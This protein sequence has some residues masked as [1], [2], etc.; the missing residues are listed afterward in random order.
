MEKVEV[1]WFRNNLRCKDNPLLL[2]KEYKV[3]PVFIF[4]EEK[5]NLRANF[6]FK[7]ILNLKENL[8]NMAL[9]L[10]LFYGKPESVFDYIKEKFEIVKIYTSYDKNFPEGEEKNLKEKYN[11]HIIYDSFFIEPKKILS[12]EAK[13]Y[14]VFSHFKE[15]AFKFLDEY[16]LIEYKSD[17]GLKLI[18]FEFEKMI[19][20]KENKIDKLPVKL[21]SLDSKK[22]EI[23]FEGALSTPEELLKRFEEIIENYEEERDFPYFNS[24]SLLSVPL[25]FGTISI[26]GV[27]RW[28]LKQDKRK[29]FIEEL[30]WREFFN[31]LFFH[32]PEAENDGL[33]Q[34]KINWAGDEKD[35]EKWKKGK[36]GVPLVDA[37]MRQLE[38]EGFMHNR[39]RM[40]V[41]DYLVK[42][43][44]INWKFGESYFEEKL[45]DYE[46]T[47]N[48]G[49]WQWVTGI[50]ADPKFLYRKFNPFLQSKKFDPQCLYIKKY[51]PE[52]K[53]LTPSKIHKGEIL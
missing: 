31:Y 17:K 36:T 37:G 44:R 50:G 52:L 27:L 6:I 39:V 53:N 18:N 46:K 19:S 38:E 32:F 5:N 34:L 23:K 13:P 22:E 15:K 24:T 4:Q 14:K 33:R 42:N 48:I 20:L 3:L 16:P 9:D 30:I 47:S 2:K 11:L 7:T 45:L 21:E 51:V 25:R 1:L 12:K 35:F 28:A 8:K 41:A 43:L 40:V 29:K 26:R 49:N 10:A